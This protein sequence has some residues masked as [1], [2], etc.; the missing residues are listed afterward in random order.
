MLAPIEVA[1]R[2]AQA[3]HAR[4][5]GQALAGEAAGVAAGR[6]LRSQTGRGAQR[7]RIAPS[8]RSIW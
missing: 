8:A 3:A 2:R 5:R 7:S 4:P 6:L 1:R